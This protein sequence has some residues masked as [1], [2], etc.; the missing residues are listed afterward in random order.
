MKSRRQI[1][2]YAAI[3]LLVALFVAAEALAVRFPWSRMIVCSEAG[4]PPYPA[5][6]Q[7]AHTAARILLAVF[8]LIAA[9][10]AIS[11]W[12]RAGRLLTGD[13]VDLTKQQAGS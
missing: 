4:P 5:C 7:Q 1:W 2:T 13:G 8:G 6:P 12:V 11:L 3:L 10:L 9:L